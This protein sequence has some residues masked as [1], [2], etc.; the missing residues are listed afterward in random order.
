M[1]F[2]VLIVNVDQQTRPILKK[3]KNPWKLIHDINKKEGD[4]RYL[5][6]SNDDFEEHNNHILKQMKKR[7]CKQC[8]FEEYLSLMSFMID[9]KQKEKEQND[10]KHECKNKEIIKEKE[11]PLSYYNFKSDIEESDLYTLNKI[12]RYQ[13]NGKYRI[14][15]INGPFRKEQEVDKYI[16]IWSTA[17]RGTI[18]KAARGEV[19]SKQFNL[20][21][22]GDLSVIFFNSDMQLSTN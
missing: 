10:Q 11:L 13:A 8:I 3:T 17:T 16:E 5:E 22:Y 4:D 18:S 14:G 12:D 21:T 15:Q 6:K 2:A 9:L 7:E 20:E 1:W 19:L